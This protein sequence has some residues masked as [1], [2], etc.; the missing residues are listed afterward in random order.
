MHESSFE[1]ESGNA[2]SKIAAAQRARWAKFRK[3]KAEVFPGPPNRGRQ[4]FGE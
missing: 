1:L 2:L 4:I 3:A